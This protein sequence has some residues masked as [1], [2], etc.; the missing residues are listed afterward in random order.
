[1]EKEG[2]K[3]VNTIKEYRDEVKRLHKL[4]EE[5]RNDVRVE[6]SKYAGHGFDIYSEGLFKAL[7]IMD[8]RLTKEKWFKSDRYF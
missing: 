3:E 7:H 6:W 8:N 4:I 1:M 5:M 2:G